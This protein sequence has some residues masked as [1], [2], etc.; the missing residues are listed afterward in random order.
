MEHTG[1]LEH[2]A[3]LA[4][5]QVLPCCE[6][7]KFGIRLYSSVGGNSYIYLLRVSIHTL[8]QCLGWVHDV[9]LPVCVPR[10]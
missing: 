8:A 9:I 4:Y 10:R 6:S 7:R 3:Y 2:I 1:A 5:L